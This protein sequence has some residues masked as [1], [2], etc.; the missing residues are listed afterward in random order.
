[1]ITYTDTLKKVFLSCIITLCIYFFYYFEFIRANIEDFSFDLINQYIFY[2]KDEIINMPKVHV[3]KVDYYYLKE[4]KLI[5][6]NNDTTYGYILPRKYLSELIEKFDKYFSYLDKKNYPFG[7]FID[8]DL[9]YK[10]D[11][12]N[13]V[14]TDDDKLL[15]ET[16][17]KDREYKIYLAKTSNQ[18][19]IETLDDDV[20]Q[21]KIKNKEI[22]FV[23]VGLSM[24]ADNITRRYNPYEEFFFNG[25][26]VK[27]PLIGLEL[28]K[29]IN[30]IENNLLET[31]STTKSS[32]IENRIL[33]KNNYE[34]EIIDNSSFIQS[35]WKNLK[36]YSA[37]F[38]LNFIPA[39][40]FSN[41]IILLGSTHE[42]S[43]DIFTKDKVNNKLSGVEVHAN[44]LLTIFYFN[45]KLKKLNL[46]YMLVIVSITIFFSDIFIKFLK[47]KYK[48]TFFFKEKAYLFLAIIV[49]SLFSYFILTFYG[50]WFNWMIP[51]VMLTI[52]P[53]FNKINW[54]KKI[55]MLK[56]LSRKN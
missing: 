32:L 33:Y 17:K 23:S 47:N 55:N 41:S 16:L 37:N 2:N 24:S 42:N 10:S 26:K 13:L 3:F 40:D 28:F 49:M 18:N 12:N 7:I 44:S 34:E 52:M 21:K 38:D 43:N 31:F 39:N 19:F 20:I 30:C 48:K 22:I 6:T 45:G 1:M 11:P 25:E 5:D 50:Y 56:K 53:F 54:I 35:Y 51:S 4:K 27:Y 46:F 14:L 9:S 15:I 8:Y 36:F 29:N